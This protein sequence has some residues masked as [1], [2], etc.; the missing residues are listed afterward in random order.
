M[1]QLPVARHPPIEPGLTSLVLGTTALLLAFLP[2]LGLP[3][4]AIGMLIGLVGIAVALTRDLGSLRWSV[5]GTI[6]CGTALAINVAL[7]Y[8]PAG[9]QPRPR[10]PQAWQSV[11]DRPWVSPPA[12]PEFWSNRHNDEQK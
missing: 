10:V 11:P 6:V 7:V 5:L 1:M 2:I 12:H 9:Y 8:A 4:S 3:L